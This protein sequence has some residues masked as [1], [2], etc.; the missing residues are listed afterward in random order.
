MNNP[1]N[2]DLRESQK[3]WLR[4]M[5]DVSAISASEL[6]RH[7]GINPSTLTRFLNS[8]EVKHTLSA[9][10]LARIEPILRKL[11]SI[12]GTRHSSDGHS[13]G[14][15]RGFVPA[16]GT[17]ARVQELL[18]HGFT[19]HGFSESDS[20][21]YAPKNPDDRLSGAIR[22]VID[23]RQNVDPWIIRSRALELAGILPGDIALVDL[24]ATPHVGDVVYAQIYDMAQMSAETIVRQYDPPYLLSA[25]L[26]RRHRRPILLDSGHVAIKGVMIALIRPRIACL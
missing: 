1:D 5:L 7:A 15:E 8:T 17:V 10:T 4:R 23:T 9:V 2:Q 6:A 21:P 16:P 20:D 14:E 26:D 18:P 3:I 13:A 12:R 19:A 24:G 22:A 11:I 25:T